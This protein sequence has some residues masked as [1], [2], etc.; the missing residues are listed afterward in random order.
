VYLEW[1]GRVVRGDLGASYRYQEPVATLIVERAPGTLALM[2]PALTLAT[3]A[4]LVLGL[5]AAD[6]RRG[7]SIVAG[8]FAGLH[9]IPSY[10]I[11]QVLVVSFALGLGWR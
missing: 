5:A 8:A 3:L 4:G 1:L 2:V 11:A 6:A 7:S 9:A 10:V